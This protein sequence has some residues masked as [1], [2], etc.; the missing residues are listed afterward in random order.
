[1]KPAL[2]LDGKPHPTVAWIEDS[3]HAGW[4]RVGMLDGTVLASVTATE[5]QSHYGVDPYTNVNPF[6]IG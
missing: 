6:S 3:G 2:G 5:L 4:R 1:M